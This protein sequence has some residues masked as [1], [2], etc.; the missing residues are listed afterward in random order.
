MEMFQAADLNNAGLKLEQAG[1]YT[2][3]EA[4]YL[5]ALELKTSFVG[6][7][8]FQAALTQNC[9]GELYMKMGRLNEAQKMLELALIGRS[10]QFN[11]KLPVAVL[12]WGTGG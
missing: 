11:L 3:A 6:A 8:S 7:T 4:N 2:A 9:L 5:R 10:G 12:E 1:E